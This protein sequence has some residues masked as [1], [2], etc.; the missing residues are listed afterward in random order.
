LARLTTIGSAATRR[1]NFKMLLITHNAL[2]SVTIRD[3]HVAAVARCVCNHLTP[4][5]SF[6]PNVHPNP[7]HA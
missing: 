5:L 4:K 6:I 3:E 2:Y 7:I 1:A